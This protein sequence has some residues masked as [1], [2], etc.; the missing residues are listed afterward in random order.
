MRRFLMITIVVL[1]THR[2]AWAAYP[3][4]KTLDAPPKKSEVADLRSRKSGDDWPRF[5]G[6]AGDSKSRE[7]GILK[8]WPKDGLMVVWQMS[9]GDGYGMPTTSRGR[10]FQFHQIKDQATLSCV[11]SETGKKLWEFGY[12]TAYRDFLGYD[13]GPRCSPVVD[14]GRVYL[15]GAEGQLHCLRVTDGTM[16]WRVNTSADFGVKQNF[17]GV[18]STPVIEG[19]LLIAQVGGSPKTSAEVFTGRTKGNGSA[20]VA[21]NKFTGKVVYKFSNEL[22]SY[23]GPKL[24]TI[25]GR[26]WCFVFARGGLIGF[27]PASGKEDFTYPWRSKVLESVNA[28]TPV[29][30]DDQVFISETYGPGSS[31]LRVKPGGHEVVWKD[32]VRKRAK[33]MKAHWNTPVY[34]DGFLY[35]SSGRHTREAELRCIELATGKVQWSEPRLGRSS[36]LLVDGCLICL[37]EHGTLRLLRANPKKYDLVSKLLLKDRRHEKEREA[38]GLPLPRLLRYP[39]W[40]APILSHGLLYARGTDRL[41]CLEL[42]PAKRKASPK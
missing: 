36:L 1:L 42:I 29:V 37:S 16:L 14:D 18:G 28:S 30:V 11:H 24:A 7:T 23:S 4:T 25:R 2:Q 27:E 8:P 3:P 38:L 15:Y 21:F 33:A 5:L 13:N 40:S 9:L 17:F 10:L 20:V 26:R 39:A 34:A 41:V 35:G 31:L 6:P 32:D 19:D 22:A 12:E